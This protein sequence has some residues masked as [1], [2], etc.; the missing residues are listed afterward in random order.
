MSRNKRSSSANKGQGMNWINR[1]R[2]LAIYL[3]DG[4]ACSYCQRGVEDGVK[5]TLDHI[6]CRCKGGD[7]RN[8]N[9]VTSCHSCN[10]RRRNCTVT[11][12]SSFVIIT[13][14][15]FGTSARVIYNR[16]QAFRRRKVDVRQ[17][18]TILASREA[19]PDCL[20]RAA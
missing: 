6:V 7:N 1:D 14:A 20:K 15:K 8:S 16:V 4:L 2:R 10:S 3:R 5:L 17:A 13:A 19:W 12:K 9:L 11:M 18:R